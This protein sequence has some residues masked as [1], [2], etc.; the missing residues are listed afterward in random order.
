VLPCEQGGTPGSATL[1][2]AAPAFTA[3]TSTKAKCSHA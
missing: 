1:V 3:A 2:L